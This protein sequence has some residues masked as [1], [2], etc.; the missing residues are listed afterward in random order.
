MYFYKYLCIFKHL[1]AHFVLLIFFLITLVIF[2][3][4]NEIYTCTFGIC[5]YKGVQA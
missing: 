1:K 4:Y 2:K 5:I 3:K